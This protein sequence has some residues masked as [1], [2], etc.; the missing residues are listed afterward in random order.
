LNHII[1]ITGLIFHDE[2]NAGHGVRHITK[3]VERRSVQIYL[4][5]YSTETG[6]SADPIRQE[7]KEI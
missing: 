4:E 3:N 7:L 5:K 2:P 1:W 6:W